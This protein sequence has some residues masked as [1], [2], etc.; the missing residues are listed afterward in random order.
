MDTVS[1]RTLTSQ[2]P[3]TPKPWLWL[4]TPLKVCC[5]G[6]LL[7][8]V[9][10]LILRL[11]FGDRWW[12]L[13]F[14]NS[15]APVWFIPLAVITPLLGLLR[16]GWWRLGAAL[17]I[18]AGL[19]FGPYFLP[20]QPGTPSGRTIKVVTF[21]MWANNQHFDQVEAWL[22]QTNPDVIMLQE[23]PD[24]YAQNGVSALSAP[25]PHQFV[26]TWGWGQLT[27]SKYPILDQK[28]IPPPSGFIF[29]RTVIDLDGQPVAIYNMHLSM[30]TQEAP[31]LVIPRAPFYV[32]IALKYDDTTRNNEIA[33]LLNML[34]TEPLPYLVVGDF[35]TSDQSVSYQ[36]LHDK[37]GDTFR[38]AGTGF[39]GSWP[40][41]V[42]S[43]LPAWLPP[44]I[45]IDYIFHSSHWQA[46][47][48]SVGPYL[49]SDHLPMIGL[50]SLRP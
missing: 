21:N 38:E 33:F 31:R 12:W 26:Q 29:Q 48:A 17:V 39:G 7:G 18:T 37:L 6:Y 36:L 8:L 41:P 24:K 32:N 3:A 42:V 46:I 44:I 28:N 16:S 22:Q 43:E 20:K 25:Y 40:R 35:N 14:L 49:G 9:C 47:D 1:T 23:I 27:L 5:A 10:F 45:R 2:A 11:S 50:L 4:L 19:W 34:K 30:P 15:F 13:G